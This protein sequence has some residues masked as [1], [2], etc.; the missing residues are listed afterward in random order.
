MTAA[1][2]RITGRHQVPAIE[3]P[4]SGAHPRRMTLRQICLA[5][6]FAASTASAADAQCYAEYKAKRD[7]PLRLHYGIVAL[8]GDC[9]SRGTA[10]R[11]VAARLA[12]AGWQL[13]TIVGLQSA[14]PTEDQRSDAGAHYLRY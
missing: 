3:Y 1:R 4:A 5:A 13:L 9:P 10:E 7:D 11:A 2:Y 8:S 14:P 6:A 12:P